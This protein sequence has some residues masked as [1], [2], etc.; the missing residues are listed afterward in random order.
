M[1]NRKKG[2]GFLVTL[3]AA[4]AFIIGASA[5]SWAASLVST[6][7]TVASEILSDTASTPIG[8]G[9]TYTA[10]APVSYQ[11]SA[12]MTS[13][14]TFDLKLTN[15]VF[16]DDDLV[17]GPDNNTAGCKV[18]A[19]DNSTATCTVGSNGMTGG[20]LYAITIDNGTGGATANSPVI[21]I[22]KGLS[23]GNTV[24]MAVT[25]SS[26]AGN[27]AAPVTLY[28]IVNQFSATIE[29]VT[30]KIDFDSGMKNFVLDTGT[31]ATA[32]TAQVYVASDQT[33]DN[34][35]KVDNATTGIM[36][37]TGTGYIDNTS[38]ILDFTV[39]GD[40]TGVKLVNNLAV[41]STELSNKKL[42]RTL[43]GNNI[44]VNGAEAASDVKRADN[45]TIT[46][47][48]TT[49]ITARQFTTAVAF[50]KAGDIGQATTLLGDTVSHIWKL[51]ATQYY[52]PLVKADAASGRD[53]Y[54]KI[55]S[56]SQVA[57]SNGVSI[58]YLAEDG[59]MYTYTPA[60]SSVTPGTPLTIDAQKIVDY[61]ASAG[62][63]VD[64]VKGFA[65]IVTV[66]APEKDLFLYANIIDPTGAKRVPVKAVGGTIVE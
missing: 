25:N 56:K 27:E 58:S 50:E 34:K 43:T 48:G 35:I 57:G 38:D 45:V 63:S 39:Q 54:I 66:N 36:P 49:V 62:H 61:A 52:I 10:S 60:P 53:T 51:N 9:Q 44:L 59:N 37:N 33:I 6:P 19:T 40:F 11:P 55:Q 26:V 21:Y 23:A 2:I 64:G 30:S 46:V 47:D 15:G 7:K 12:S 4:V 32:S 14:E 5:S 31:T 1:G 28:T 22:N 17:I 42:V 13:G 18:S 24:S 29:P 65:V 8:Y 41:S 16:K 20:S 3:L